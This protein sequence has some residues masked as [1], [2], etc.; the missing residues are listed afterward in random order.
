MEA[1]STLAPKSWKIRSFHP[2]DVGAFG[3]LADISLSSPEASQFSAGDYH[4]I[5]C[6]EGG[7]LLLCEW[8]AH[9]CGFLAG[10]QAAGE[11]EILNFAVHP[12]FRRLGI[13]SALLS[14]ALTEFTEKGI[15]SVFLEVRESNSPALSLYQKFGFAIA[16]RRKDYYRD[17]LEDGLCLMR[18]LPALAS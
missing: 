2:S 12:R 7:I 9:I 17:P 14:A 3:A 11:A 5:A 16:S 10:R 1:E 6:T 18:K 15:A 13:A 8:D 4:G